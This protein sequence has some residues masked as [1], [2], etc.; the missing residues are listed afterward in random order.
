MWAISLGRPVIEIAHFERM[1]LDGFQLLNPH[2][3]IGFQR[4]RKG[5]SILVHA[6]YTLLL[7][8]RLPSY[9]S[10]SLLLLFPSFYFYFLLSLVFFFPFSLFSPVLPS[11]AFS[12]TVK[13][14]FYITYRDGFLL[15]CPLTA[16]ILV[17]VSFS[18][19]PLDYRLPS[20]HHL[21]T[22]AVPQPI[23]RQ[24][25][26]ILVSCSLWHSHPDKGGHSLLL[27]PIACTQ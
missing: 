19:H 22:L 23:P 24:K 3:R 15:F 6:Y 4:E 11:F 5:D 17:Q 27:S 20:H 7:A 10:S 16:F 2:Q 1:G 18:E 25:N 8:L 21:P 26:F 12:C 9:L 13:A 14:L